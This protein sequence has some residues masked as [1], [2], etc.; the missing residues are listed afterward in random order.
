MDAG[1]VIKW[2]NFHDRQY[3]GEVK[4]RWF[5]YMGD[6]GPFSVFR[7]AYLFTTTGQVDKFAPGGQREGHTHCSFSPQTSPFEQPCMMDFDEEPYTYQLS[8]IENHP[9]IDVKDKLSVQDI[10]MIYNRILRSSTLNRMGKLNI[11]DSLVRSGVPI[12]KKP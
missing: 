11:Y 8:F 1:T 6:T 4:P 5:V 7:I 9:D 3:E 2:N 10:Q 12:S